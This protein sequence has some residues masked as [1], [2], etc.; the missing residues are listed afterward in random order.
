MYFIQ[1]LMQ[2][3]GTEPFRSLNYLNQLSDW[4]DLS[5]KCYVCIT[6]EEWVSFLLIRCVYVSCI[7][8]FQLVESTTC[9][10]REQEDRTQMFYLPVF[11]ICK[12]RILPSKTAS[13][14][15]QC[16][17]ASEMKGDTFFVF[18]FIIGFLFASFVYAPFLPTLDDCEGKHELK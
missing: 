15:T 1:L 18:L 14:K 2:K 16:K 17:E 9:S 6:G 13:F 5:F 10:G 3:V 4:S 11:N 8:E 7:I 12:F